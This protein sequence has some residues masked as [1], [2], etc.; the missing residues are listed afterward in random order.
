MATAI[1]ILKNITVLGCVCIASM[2][3]YFSFNMP[4]KIWGDEVLFPR[5]VT[6]YLF[7][8]IGGF[9]TGYGLFRSRRW[10]LYLFTLLNLVWA[11][12]GFMTIFGSS[13]HQ[14]TGFFQTFLEIMFLVGIPCAAVLVFWVL[15]KRIF[16]YAPAG[17]IMEKKIGKYWSFLASS[18]CQSQ[19]KIKKIDF[20]WDYFP[21][22]FTI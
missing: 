2:F 7:I 14:N 3:T 1:Q 22:H 13:G 12:M 21:T 5:M 15:R 8:I 16:D 17:P 10:S 9:A 19:K 11:A 20:K 6:L 18:F 4:V